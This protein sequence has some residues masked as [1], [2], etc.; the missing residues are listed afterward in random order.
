[1]LPLIDRSER[2]DHS[3]S[4]TDS[5][6]RSSR[7]CSR[8]DGLDVASSTSAFAY[9]ARTD[10]IRPSARNSVCRISWEGS[11]QRVGDQLRITAALGET[12]PMALKYGAS[13]LANGG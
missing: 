2:R 1:V 11:L 10:D 4:R 7:R 12:S 13:L 5:P 6:K 3:I 9:R 8:V